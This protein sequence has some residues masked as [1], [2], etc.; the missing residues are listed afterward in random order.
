MNTDQD[1]IYILKTMIKSN[2]EKS[3]L[4]EEQKKVAEESVLKTII[5][6][7][8]VLEKEKIIEETKLQKKNLIEEGEKEKEK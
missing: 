8:I 6:S 4:N 3:N 5:E 1:S 7:I 2:F